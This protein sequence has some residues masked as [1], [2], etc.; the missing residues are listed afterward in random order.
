MRQAGSRCRRAAG[1]AARATTEGVLRVPRGRRRLRLR[2]RQSQTAGAPIRDQRGAA[3]LPSLLL[4]RRRRLPPRGTAAAARTRVAAAGCKV[5][6][7][8]WALAAAARA[9]LRAAGWAGGT[10]CSVGG[11][12]EVGGAAFRKAQGEGSRMRRQHA[13]RDAAVLASALHGLAQAHGDDADDAPH[14]LE[15]HRGIE[16]G[17]KAGGGEGA[18]E[19]GQ[20][21]L[22][23]RQLQRGEGA[24]G[25]RTA[26]VALPWLR[27]PAHCPLSSLTGAGSRRARAALHVVLRGW[28]G[29]CRS[30]RAGGSAWGLALSRPPPPSWGASCCRWWTLM[31]AWNDG[32]ATSALESGLRSLFGDIVLARPDTGRRSCTLGLPQSRI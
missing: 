20:D 8:S 24:A 31:V 10:A 5:L 28:L 27:A 4:P 3:L 19:N 14:G 1:G 15:R 2:A 7:A 25:V 21:F 18:R 16:S 32:R 23:G 13:G 29:G 12:A 11:Q 30:V 22:R 26:R 17:R 6:P 9:W